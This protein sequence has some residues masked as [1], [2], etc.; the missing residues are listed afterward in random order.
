MHKEKNCSAVDQLFS[1]Q[2]IEAQLCNVCQR[3]SFSCQTF[4]ILAVPL[5]DPRQ[6]NGL[7]YLEDCLAHFT[8]V[9]ELCGDNGLQCACS[10]PSLLSSS[11]GVATS[12]QVSPINGGLPKLS[13]MHRKRL[14]HR[15]P[16]SRNEVV[17]DS[18]YDEGYF[19]TS[20]PIQADGKM[21]HV[22]STPMKRLTDGQRR[23][24]ISQL[25][26]CLV[27]QLMRFKYSPNR[28]AVYKVKSP[29]N[30]PMVGLDMTHL[31]MSNVLSRCVP[32]RNSDYPANYR[33][34][35]SGLCVHIGDAGANGGHY[36]S[37]TKARNG[38]WYKFD[39]HHVTEVNM[40]YELAARV[41]KENA[42]LLFYRKASL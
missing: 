10:N 13:D 41:V 34:N 20:T 29:V 14:N 3:V 22:L 11:D 42:Y 25:P 35:L 16:L 38:R 36:M 26:D 4:N 32:P 24:M 8:R 12:A 9:E 30:I 2:L 15:T 19:K 21:D 17:E 27:I 39:D 5:A 28:R 40:E 31:L 6:G 23:S 1:G 33:Y 18:G 7:T 37:Y